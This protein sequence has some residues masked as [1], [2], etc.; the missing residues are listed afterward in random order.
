MS[1]I[2]SLDGHG[3]SLS[4]PIYPGALLTV[5]QSYLLVFQYATRHGL[6]TKAFTELLH[7]LSVHAPLGSSIPKSV[8]RLKCFFVQAFPHAKQ[9]KISIVPSVRDPS[10][11]L[12]P[13]VVERGVV[14]NQLPSLSPS[15][16][17]PRS[18]D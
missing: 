8:H 2:P 18:S 4:K 16:L 13:H 1:G 5:L 14:M 6:T 11:L 12:Q 17:D 3:S 10:H 9:R 7:V 15:P